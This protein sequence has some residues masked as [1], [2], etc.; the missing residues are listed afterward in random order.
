MIIFTLKL[1]EFHMDLAVLK[2]HLTKCP[3]EWEPSK[4]NG[5]SIV[6][7]DRDYNVPVILPVSTI[8]H[9]EYH[10]D[11]HYFSADQPDGSTKNYYTS[12]GILLIE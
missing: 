11:G 6:I 7:L 10:R 4:L 1:K 8:T 12:D 5:P 9:C 3:G 2:E